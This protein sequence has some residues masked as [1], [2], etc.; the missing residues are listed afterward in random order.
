MRKGVDRSHPWFIF[1]FDE[2]ISQYML[3]IFYI[4]RL[5]SIGIGNLSSIQF[6]RQITLG[7]NLVSL[8]A[9]TVHS[10]TEFHSI[11]IVSHR[12]ITSMITY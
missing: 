3:T 9:D 4:E 10:N 8:P 1:V 12:D 6:L 5:N 11:V 2:L 7:V